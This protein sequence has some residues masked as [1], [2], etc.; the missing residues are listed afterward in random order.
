MPPRAYWKGFV[1]IQTITFPARLYGAVNTAATITFHEIHKDCGQ[2]IRN[3]KVCPEHGEIGNDEII[4]G[5][6]YKKDEY[7]EID[8]E[9]LA[10][11]KPDSTK[12]IEIE[13]FVKLEELKPAYLD[14]P[15]YL[16]PDGPVAEDPY[17]VVR[18]A[19]RNSETAA[20]GNVIIAKRPYV[21]S[22]MAKDNG[23]VMYKLRAGD[24]V[25]SATEYFED[26]KNG[27]ALDKESLQMAESLIERK[28]ARFDLGKFE[29]RYKDALAKLIEAKLQGKSV[30][31]P[32]RQPAKVIDIREALKRSLGQV[33]PVEEEP[34][35]KK[36]EKKPPAKTAA[37][38]R[39]GRKK[40][41]AS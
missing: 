36:T 15:Y 39:G 2:R 27:A 22:I 14:R 8:E 29:D 4:R 7:V 13:N 28:R 10:K 1:K 20:I 21:V 11:L 5:Y 25:R 38:A 37:R 34:E 26:I 32:K 40:K 6:E 18:E 19:M 3:A 41:R 9:D 30:T 24:E 12:T 17:R 35:K 23:L 16:A 31:T 33:A